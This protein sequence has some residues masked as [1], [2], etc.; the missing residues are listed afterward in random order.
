MTTEQ[1]LE[2]LTDQAIHACVRILELR[3]DKD[4]AVRQTIRGFIH[5]YVT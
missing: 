4:A 5:G 3:E 1:A 2:R